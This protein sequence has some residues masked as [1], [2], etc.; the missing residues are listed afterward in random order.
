MQMMVFKEIL[1]NPQGF[2]SCLLTVNALERRN[3]YQE[4]ASVVK[5]VENAHPTSVSWLR[6]HVQ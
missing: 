5:I 6:R 1:T 3:I 2:W 4:V